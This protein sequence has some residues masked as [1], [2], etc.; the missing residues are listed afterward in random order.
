MKTRK[1]K[2]TLNYNSGKTRKLNNT[3]NSQSK[4]KHKNTYTQ[5]NLQGFTQPP[6]YPMDDP[7]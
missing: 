6:P 5:A 7:T 3:P 1:L 4:K 2:N